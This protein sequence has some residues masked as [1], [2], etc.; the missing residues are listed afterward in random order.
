ML[1][2]LVS[3]F[4]EPPLKDVIDD[5]NEVKKSYS[6]WRARMFYSCFIGYTTFYLCK[7]I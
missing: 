2:F 1:K 6:H 7:K 5:E 3:F 4:K